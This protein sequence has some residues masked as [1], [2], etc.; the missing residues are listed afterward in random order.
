MTKL[1]KKSK[2]KKSFL[3][4][5]KKIWLIAKMQFSRKSQNKMQF[6]IC[7]RKPSPITLLSFKLERSRKR[8]L[9]SPRKSLLNRLLK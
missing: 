6:S 1:P 4:R 9:C 2:T 3:L 7:T 5:S 8:R